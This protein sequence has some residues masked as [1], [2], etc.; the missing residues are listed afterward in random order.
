MEKIG[1]LLRSESK[2]WNTLKKG[3]KLYLMIPEFKDNII[4]YSYQESEVIAIKEYNLI[5]NLRFKYT[6]N[7]K[8]KRVNLAI[9]KL[10]YELPYL[11]VKKNTQW[12]REYTPAYG[13]IIIS[14]TSAESLNDIYI[15]LVSNEIEKQEQII[16]E[17][18]KML[19]ILRTV[20]Y[21]KIV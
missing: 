18:K 4:S 14:F 10:K 7:G 5:C 17:H 15:K 11:A 1:N 12:A 20:Q 8:R 3:D 21:G 13:D 19:N 2:K 9:N 6:D 16:E